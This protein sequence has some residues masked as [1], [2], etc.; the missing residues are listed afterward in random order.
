MQNLIQKR[1]LVVTALSVLLIG[2]MILLLC[3][4]FAEIKHVFAPYHEQSTL[5]LDA[6]HPRYHMREKIRT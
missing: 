4:H 3:Q 6:G 1:L 5:V 2:G